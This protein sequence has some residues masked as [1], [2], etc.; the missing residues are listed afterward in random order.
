MNNTAQPVIVTDTDNGSGSAVLSVVVTKSDRQVQA[1]T[2][3]LVA[4]A[5]DFQDA[6]G[7]ISIVTREQYDR[8]TELVRLVAAHQD[9]IKDRHRDVKAKAF[10]LHRSICDLENGE[11]KEPNRL[12]TAL[13][14]A[15]ERFRRLD[16]E[17]QLQE[18]EKIRRELQAAAETSVIEQATELLLTGQADEGARLLSSV[19]AGQV[20]PVTVAPVAVIRPVKSE[21]IGLRKTKKFRMID[22]M[23]LLRPYLMPDEKLI[24]RVVTARGKD[25]E[26]LV[27]PGSIEVY[28]KESESVR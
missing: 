21:G 2:A 11:L 13:K 14:I 3:A 10:Q 4:A 22:P 17:R 26:Q 16:E 7:T 28:E 6:G 19:G 18:S 5:A 1:Q 27:G 25:A 23:K 12:E 15:R 8:T 24:Q 9:Y 20:Q